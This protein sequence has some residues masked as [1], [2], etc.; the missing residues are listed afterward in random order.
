MWIFFNPKGILSYNTEYTKTQELKKSVENK[1]TAIKIVELEST[2][3]DDFLSI[4][5]ST[6][7]LSK[8]QIQEILDS[9]AIRLLIERY[10][11][12]YNLLE[13]DEQ[14]VEIKE[15]GPVND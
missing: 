11:I 6:N 4:T 9:K 5:D 2:Y 12:I 7:Q 13:K 14:K 15:K 3:L 1:K 8:K 10:L